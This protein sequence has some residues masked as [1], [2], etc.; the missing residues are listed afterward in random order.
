MYPW[1]SQQILTG[2][3][4]GNTIWTHVYVPSGCGVP[5]IT[6]EDET[7]GQSYTKGI[8]NSVCP[9]DTAEW[10]LERTEEGGTYP[11]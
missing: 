3:S 9:D 7:T 8:P 5:S 6:V 2:V 1:N 10:I 4:A 11:H